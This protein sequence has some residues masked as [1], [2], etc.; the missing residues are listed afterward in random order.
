MALFFIEAIRFDESGKRIEKVRWGR[1]KGGQV[2]P[3]ATVD[4]PQEVDVGVV[5]DT[6]ANGDEVVTKLHGDR[7]IVLG[8]KVTGVL[9][10]DGVR[11]LCGDTNGDDTVRLHDL[12]SF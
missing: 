12:P 3:P 4:D 5:W 1:S 2:M 10:E 9:Y 8:E 11:G 7:G 6:I